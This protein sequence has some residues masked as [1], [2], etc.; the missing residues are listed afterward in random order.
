M[1]VNFQEPLLIICGRIVRNIRDFIELND[2][3]KIDDH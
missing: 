3:R 1:K 2:L